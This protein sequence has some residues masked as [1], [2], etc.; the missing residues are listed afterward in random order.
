LYVL[1]ERAPEC[2]GYCAHCC[3]RAARIEP[4]GGGGG[5]GGRMVLVGRVGQHTEGKIRAVAVAKKMFSAPTTIALP[6]RTIIPYMLPRVRVVG[7]GSCGGSGMQPAKMNGAVGV[8]G[9]C[10]C[11]RIRWRRR[12]LGN[13]PQKRQ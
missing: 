8:I 11:C 5:G 6:L 2:D 1:K 4:A 12:R 9:R 3:D 10:R 13:R 7:G